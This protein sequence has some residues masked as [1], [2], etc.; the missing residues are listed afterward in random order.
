MALGAALV[1]AADSGRAAAGSSSGC[2]LL[3]E[4]SLTDAMAA[5]LC[6][7]AVL[8]GPLLSSADM[9]CACMTRCFVG[10]LKHELQQQC[11]P[12]YLHMQLGAAPLSRGPGWV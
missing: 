9:S 5:G 8:T 11:D 4:S 2:A 6:E 7:R 10:S 1:S 12:D 3:Y